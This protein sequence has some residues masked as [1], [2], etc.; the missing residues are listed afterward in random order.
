MLRKKILKKR[1][2]S[3]EELPPVHFDASR[4]KQ[5]DTE[6][7]YKDRDKVSR[8]L[9]QCLAENDPVSFMEILNAYLRVNKSHIAQETGLLRTTINAALSQGNPTLKTL[10]KIV[11]Q[12]EIPRHS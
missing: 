5:T 1:V 12:A 7:F 9:F 3:L 8:A 11:H 2:F 4:F 6:S 10:A